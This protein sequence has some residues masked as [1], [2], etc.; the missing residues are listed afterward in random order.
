MKIYTRTG[1]DGTTSLYGGRR[2]SKAD[3]RV[4]AYGTLD[5]AN[6]AVGLA[7]SFGL[8]RV[9]DGV[10]EALQRDL[11]TIGAEVASGRN[12]ASKLGMAL[13]DASDVA[14]LEA[15][16][17][18]AEEH[19]EPLTS[20]ILP[21]GT[22]AA[23]ALHVARTVVRRAERCLVALNN[24]EDVRREVIEYVNRASDLFFVLAR[25]ANHVS[26]VSDVRWIPSK[27]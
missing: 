25:R 9:S 27:A 2:V 20:F 11:F 5:E 4:E 19:L 12:A 26:G 21:G 1:D 18:Q 23:S 22:A 7:R 10:L 13:V 17:D 3:A 15:A 14:R 6:S 16:I 8:D 24:D